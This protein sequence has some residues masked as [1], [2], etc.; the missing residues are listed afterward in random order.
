MQYRLVRLLSRRTNSITVVGDEDQSI[1]RWRG[2]DIRNILD[3]E[4]DHPGARV[5]K[6]E[7]N[8]RSTGQHPAPP[9]T[10]SSRRTPS[11]GRSALHRGGGGR[12]DR[13]VRGRDR[14]RRGGVRRQPHRG[15]RCRR[16]WR[17]ATSRSSTGPTPS[18]ACW[19]TRCA[20]AICPTRS[21]AARASSTAPRSRTWSRYLRAVANPDDGIALQRII[22]V[23]ARGIGAT[24][25]DRIGDIIYE[26]KIPAWQALELVARGRA[27]LGSAGRARRSPRSS[28]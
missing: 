8:Y 4:R 15:R 2:A 19:K 22:N 11:G 10:R 24:T 3:F 13:A 17:R 12:A 27:L 7:H 26:R 5:V 9:P 1:Y 14:A 25:V 23:P 18:R 28:R 16:R 21:S 6:L 20:R